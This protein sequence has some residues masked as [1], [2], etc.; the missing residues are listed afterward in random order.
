MPAAHKIILRCLNNSCV[1]KNYLWISDD[2]SSYRLLEKR[3]ENRNKYLRVQ[4]QVLTLH[5]LPFYRFFCFVP[6]SICKIWKVISLLQKASIYPIQKML[7]G[8]INKLPSFNLFTNRLCCDWC[9]IMRKAT[10]RA[11]LSVCVCVCV[12]VCG[13]FALKV[14]RT[15]CASRALLNPEASRPRHIN[16]GPALTDQ[17]TGTLSPLLKCSRCGLT[18]RLYKDLQNR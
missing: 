10:V 3:F 9:I 2:S 11:A 13:R 14:R 7:R 6:V 17:L 12:L 4:P 18:K 1:L 8:F 5:F 16:L 15:G